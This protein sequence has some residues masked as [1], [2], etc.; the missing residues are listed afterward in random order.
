MLSEVELSFPRTD[1]TEGQDL[2]SHGSAHVVGW[3]ESLP[4]SASWPGITPLQ[5]VERG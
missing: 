4:G 1:A 3:D 2:S 5:Q